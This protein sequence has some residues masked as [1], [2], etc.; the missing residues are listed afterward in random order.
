MME[1]KA[2]TRINAVFVARH[3]NAASDLALDVFE[4]F[5]LLAVADNGAWH[6]PPTPGSSVVQPLHLN[7]TTD[8]VDSGFNN[9][10]TT[11]K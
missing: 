8:L 9:R 3:F 10:P 6:L 5:A 7:K 11:T 4:R 1:P 2:L